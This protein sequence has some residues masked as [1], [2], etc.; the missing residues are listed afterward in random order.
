MSVHD[1]LEP[2]AIEL[3]K[4]IAESLRP[5]G[6]RELGRRLD[7]TQRISESTVNRLLRQDETLRR[8]LREAYNLPA[9][10]SSEDFA[11]EIAADRRRN[12]ALVAGGRAMFE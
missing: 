4:L 10:G 9:G 11:R 6:A 3:L 1:A 2:R 7:G 12:R 5:L 8:R